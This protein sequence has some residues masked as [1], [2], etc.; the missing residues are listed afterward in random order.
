MPLPHNRD[1]RAGSFFMFF[2]P[3]SAVEGIKLILSVYFQTG[4]PVQIYYLMSYTAKTM[5][6]FA[7]FWA[8][9]LTRRAWRVFI[10]L[11]F[12]SLS[13]VLWYTEDNEGKKEAHFFARYGCE[14]DS[15][16]QL[17][18]Q[19]RR[20]YR[21]EIGIWVQLHLWASQSSRRVPGEMNSLVV[22]PPCQSAI[23]VWQC[24]CNMFKDVPIFISASA[25]SAYR[26]F[27]S[28]SAYRLSANIFSADIWISAFGDISA[29]YR[30][31][32][33][34]VRHISKRSARILAGLW[35]KDGDK[36]QFPHFVTSIIGTMLNC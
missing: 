4:W 3:A 22:L 30:L 26:H 18:T 27:F 34:I 8:W 35:N 25:I 32:I 11:Y 7:V 13:G 10:S 20:K 14:M 28:I 9:I 19:N 17:H 21:W 31:N 29:K 33:S 5:T 36:Q 6:S 15:H 16:F 12:G 2:P 1:P 23:A 24:T